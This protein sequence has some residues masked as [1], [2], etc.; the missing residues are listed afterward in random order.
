V[1]QGLAWR[2]LEAPHER[3]SWHGGTTPFYHSG[4]AVDDDSQVGLVL[5]SSA[6]DTINFIEPL[7]TL[8]GVKALTPRFLRW[9]ERACA[10]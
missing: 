8:L 9:F 2:S 4:L 7:A 1:L 10:L 3:A 6:H 5:L